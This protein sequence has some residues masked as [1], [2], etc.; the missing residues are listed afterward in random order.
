MAAGLS[1]VA[2]FLLGRLGF[3]VSFLGFDRAL[4][5]AKY[6]SVLVRHDEK[7]CLEKLSKT[8]LFSE[9]IDIA[10]EIEL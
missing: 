1:A 8:L 3:T 10:T 2:L 4:V 6:S 5:L 7:V 9:I